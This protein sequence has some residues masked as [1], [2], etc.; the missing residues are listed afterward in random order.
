MLGTNQDRNTSIGLLILRVGFSVLLFFAHGWLKLANFESE[1][2]PLVSKLDAFDREELG[3]R[4]DR[5]RKEHKDPS[6][7]NW[8]VLE[9]TTATSSGGATLT[10]Q[11]DGSFLASGKNPKFDTYT[12]IAKTRKSLK[13]SQS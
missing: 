8:L 7:S 12:F 11:S 10:K 1:H 2:A 4:F 6:Q 5:W 13:S 3:S 9:P